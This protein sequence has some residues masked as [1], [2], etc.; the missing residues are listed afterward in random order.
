LGLPVDTGALVIDVAPGGPADKAGIVPG[1]V[2]L[3][4]GDRDVMS[5]VDIREAVTSLDPEDQVEVRVVHADGG[6]A[7]FT[8]T[9]GVRPFPI[10][11]E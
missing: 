3:S 11:P 7:T 1:D 4:I 6:E 10:G 8:V 2:I 5:S 9:L